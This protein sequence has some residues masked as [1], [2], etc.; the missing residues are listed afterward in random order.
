MRNE[1][2]ASPRLE[3]PAA[4]GPDLAREEEPAHWRAEQVADRVRVV[5]GHVE[6]VRPPAVAGEEQR[7][8]ESQTFSDQVSEWLRVTQGIFVDP[9]ADLGW[10]A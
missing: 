10:K 2:A 5:V 4:H 8:L 1:D 6:H 9:S 3:V 7:P